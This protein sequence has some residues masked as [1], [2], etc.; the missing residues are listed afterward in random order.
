MK[1][2]DHI[3]KTYHLIRKINILEIVINKGILHH[4]LLNR[5]YDK[6]NSGLLKVNL[7]YWFLLY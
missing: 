2:I 1:C 4:S 5:F 7:L 3:R 6:K